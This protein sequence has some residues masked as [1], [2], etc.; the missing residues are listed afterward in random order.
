MSRIGKLA[1]NIPD[2]VRIELKGDHLRVQG[3]KGALEHRLP[4]GIQL[5]G[6]N[7][8]VIDVNTELFTG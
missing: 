3:P 5:D 4:K 7:A 2:G 6:F 8:R 1:I